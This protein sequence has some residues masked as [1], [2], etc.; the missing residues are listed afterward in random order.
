MTEHIN[1][2]TQE[3]ITR[4]IVWPVVVTGC[5]GICF[6]IAGLIWATV[7]LTKQVDVEKHCANCFAH[8][9]CMIPMLFITMTICAIWF[10]VETGRYKYEGTL[11][12]DITIVEFEEFFQQYDNVRFEDGLWKWE[13]KQ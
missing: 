9:A 12:S 10:P 11:D 2:I 6:V 13:D 4:P 5:I 3:A 1:I 8:A 7:G